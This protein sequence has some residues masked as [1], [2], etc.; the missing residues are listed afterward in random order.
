MPAT[1]VSMESDTGESAAQTAGPNYI[2]LGLLAAG[3]V[4]VVGVYL[5]QHMSVVSAYMQN[6]PTAVAQQPETIAIQTTPPVTDNSSQGAANPFSNASTA[7][8]LQETVNP[9]AT[10]TN[11]YTN[12]FNTQ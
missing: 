4:G 2:L 1:L 11:N 8:D 5:Y 6:N 3:I 7:G 9:F 12:P 10:T